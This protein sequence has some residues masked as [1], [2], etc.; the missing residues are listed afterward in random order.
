MQF[1]PVA[2]SPWAVSASEPT[3]GALVPLINEV[4]Q[5]LMSG[6]QANIDKIF[7]ITIK[8]L[9]ERQ[10]GVTQHFEKERA[11]LLKTIDQGETRIGELQRHNSDFEEAKTAQQAQVHT[12]QKELDEAKQTIEKREGERQAVEARCISLIGRVTSLQGEYSKAKED[13]DALNKQIAEKGFEKIIEDLKA[14]CRE[15]EEK[16]RGYES[17]TKEK[18][19]AISTLKGEKNELQGKL[20]AT[21]AKLNEA[22][23]TLER[24]ARHIDLNDE[25]QKDVLACYKACKQI[26]NSV[27]GNEIS[28]ALILKSF[29]SSKPIRLYSYNKLFTSALDI[30]SSFLIDIFERALPIQ[31]YSFKM[32]LVYALKYCNLPHVTKKTI[33]N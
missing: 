16:I 13:R 19:S 29:D 7:T 18:D 10:N 24:Y 6:D 12:L 22:N 8:T 15:F 5:A 4:E 27:L 1:S 28:T 9:V 25:S 23:M 33:T 20:D 17:L 31:T 14:A 26:Y 32:T 21:Q 2:A 30:S 3:D 11:R